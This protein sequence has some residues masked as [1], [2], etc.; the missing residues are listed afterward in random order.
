[1]YSTSGVKFFGL[2]TDKK[3]KMNFTVVT[4]EKTSENAR[5]CTPATTINED[6]A[7]K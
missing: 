2:L 5:L 4:H 1:M 3:E 6:I 7:E